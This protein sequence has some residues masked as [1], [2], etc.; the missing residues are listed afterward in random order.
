[1][2]LIETPAGEFDCWVDG[3]HCPDTV[4]DLKTVNEKNLS[5]LAGQPVE[6]LEIRG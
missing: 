5:G 1:M 2:E 3:K 6:I 4:A